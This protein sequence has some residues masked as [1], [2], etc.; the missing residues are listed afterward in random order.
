MGVRK[1][2]VRIYVVLTRPLGQ[3]Q[4]WR[5]SDSKSNLELTFENLFCWYKLV[6]VYQNSIQE[7]RGGQGDFILKWLVSAI[8][9]VII[10][11]SQVQWCVYPSSLSATLV[12][13]LHISRW[14]AQEFLQLRGGPSNALL[15]LHGVCWDLL[16]MAAR[17]HWPFFAFGS[18]QCSGS[19]TSPCLPTS[20]NH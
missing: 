10:M 12:S 5:W 13:Q 2:I 17:C 18:W 15:C 4:I 7:I 3:R 20:G 16:R 14:A 11:H 8:H 1:G 6:V 9:A 19:F